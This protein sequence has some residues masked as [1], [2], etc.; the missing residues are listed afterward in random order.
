MINY[1]LLRASLISS[2]LWRPR[3]GSRET[4][5][6]W[7]L[8]GALLRQ[9]GERSWC[10]GRRVVAVGGPTN[11]WLDVRDVRP[12]S[13]VWTLLVVFA[14]GSLLI[15][16][17]VR[18]EVLHGPGEAVAGQAQV[19]FTMEGKVMRG[20][21]CRS[22][23]WDV[24]ILLFILN[25]LWLLMWLWCLAQR[26]KLINTFYHLTILGDHFYFPFIK[27]LQ[28][29]LGFDTILSNPV[30]NLLTESKFFHIQYWIERYLFCRVNSFF[31]FTAFGFATYDFM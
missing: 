11:A 5:V 26:L 9:W 7:G 25:V 23:Q 18:Y 24:F 15:A 13:G 12:L 31:F 20:R 8:C 10:V 14:C 30:L 22:L 19:T 3:E 1:F 21:R 6:P 29:G 16:V 28:A 2:L 17:A 4:A 27:Q